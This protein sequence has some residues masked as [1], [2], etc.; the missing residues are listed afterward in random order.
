MRRY[1][2]L[3]KRKTPSIPESLTDAIVEAYVDMRKVN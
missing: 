1:I 3:C 2:D